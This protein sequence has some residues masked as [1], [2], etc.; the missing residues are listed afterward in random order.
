MTAVFPRVRISLPAP[1]DDPTG[2]RLLRL[3]EL[4]PT[5][6]HYA[7]VV[8]L[9]GEMPPGV[10]AACAA[11]GVPYLGR[12]PLWDDVPGPPA[13]QIRTLLTDQGRSE[14]RR[15]AALAALREHAGDEPVEQ[16]RAFMLACQPE[17]AAAPPA[18]AA[19]EPAGGELLLVRARSAA[20]RPALARH[21]AGCGWLVLMEVGAD[22]LVVAVDAD[23]RERLE[24]DPQTGFVGGITLDEDAEVAGALKRRFAEHVSRQL[25]EER[26]LTG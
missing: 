8:D 15:L 20:E 10:D 21:L 1:P 5:L 26:T 3:D 25:A 9:S 24:A 2:G 7:L 17:P 11:L 12:S 16:V 18:P 23:G 14:A 13:L 6:P 22:G 19:A 4:I